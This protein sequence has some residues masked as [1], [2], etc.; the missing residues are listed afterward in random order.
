MPRI[1]SRRFG[2]T[3]YRFCISFVGKCISSIIIVIE[4][5]MFRREQAPALRG[6][7][8]ICIYHKPSSMLHVAGAQ[9]AQGKYA[10]APTKLENHHPHPQ[11]PSKPNTPNKKKKHITGQTVVTYFFFVFRCGSWDTSASSANAINPGC[12]PGSPASHFRL[13]SS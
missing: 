9:N 5:V 7:W 11:T 2:C 1:A 8:S 12:Y 3:T 6:F 13:T 10:F 4:I